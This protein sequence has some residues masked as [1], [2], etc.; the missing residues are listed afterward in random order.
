M[1][2]PSHFHSLVF[3]LYQI[4]QYFKHRDVIERFLIVVIFPHTLQTV[5]KSG[6]GPSVWQLT[7]NI[8][9]RVQNIPDIKIISFGDGLPSF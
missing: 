8:L 9:E 6:V 5:D 7:Y 3:Q 1:P 2:I 4:F